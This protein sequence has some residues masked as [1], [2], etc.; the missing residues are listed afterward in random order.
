MKLPT[1]KADRPFIRPPEW[2]LLE[3]RLIE[4][5]NRTAEPLLRKY[6]REDGTILWPTTD[7]HV[8]IDGLDD[9]YESFANWPL[10]YLLGGADKF[11]DYALREFEAITRQFACYDTGFGHP[12]V[13]KEYEQGYDW[14]HQGEGYTLFYL[15]NM[16]D[17]CNKRLRELA[18]RFAGFYVN[19]DKDAS[20]YDP[21]IKLMRCSLVGSMGPGHELFAGSEFLPFSYQPYMQYY[22]LPFR[23]V[24]MVK[25]VED[26]QDAE[27]ATRMGEVIRRR[28]SHG[29]SAMNLAATSMV[30]N[31]YLLTGEER[32]GTWIRDYVGKWMELTRENGGILPDN[33]G[34][35]GKIGETLEGK[36][37]GSRY[38][39]AFP[40]GWLSLGC[41]TVIAAEN[42]AL[43][44]GKPAYADFPRSQIVLL[45]E[46]GIVKGSTLHV[47]HKYGDPGEYDY[48][49]WLEDVLYEDGTTSQRGR[50]RSSPILWKDGWFEFYP[51]DP[52]FMTHVWFLSM[53][54]RDKELLKRLRNERL[55]DWRTVANTAGNSGS[56][57]KAQKGHDQAWI[58]YLDGEFPDYPEQI[59]RHNLAQ[60]YQRLDYIRQD[61]QNPLTYSEAYLQARNPITVEGLVQ[62][63]T[64][65]PMHIYNGGLQLATV[66]YYD[67]ERWRPGLPED[68]A[69]LVTK[70]EAERA[71][72][73]LVNLSADEQRTV[74]VQAG[75]YGEHRFTEVRY[76][77]RAPG[78]PSPHYDPHA[79][80]VAAEQRTL[81]V[82]GRWLQVELQPGAQVTLE[83]G[84]ERFVGAPA[85]ATP[86]QELEALTLSTGGLGDDNRSKGRVPASDRTL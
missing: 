58:A 29:D 19:D 75:A 6:V 30:M 52:G 42:A 34:P 84:M 4:L 64:G 38:G 31:A 20:N 65:A 5:M 39:W 54:P 56:A 78:E 57:K 83:A 76:D 85:Y 14:F 86:W 55:Q 60:V 79:G 43:C 24:E 27:K 22:G 2:A 80:A 18:V 26:L 36:W 21:A 13:V 28:W 73:I 46:K 66:R 82:N 41:A 53:D 11:F 12:M 70:V 35:T 45:M 69:A 63:T 40:H 50:Q 10:F 3:R 7:D 1:I 62:L 74:I 48:E 25:T 23:D 47:P 68:V 67:A 71:D 77:V 59:L 15:L 9:A 72:V 32:Y 37:Y 16:A 49:L 17:P 33:A 8:G 51:M 44:S 61:R 81:A